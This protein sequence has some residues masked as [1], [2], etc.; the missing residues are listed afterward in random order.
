[1]H[2]KKPWHGEFIQGLWIIFTIKILTQKNNIGK[3]EL[4][5]I[6]QRRGSM[7]EKYGT[8]N[9]EGQNVN[10]DKLPIEEIKKY[11]I[12]VNEKEQK[13]ISQQ[14]EYLSQMIG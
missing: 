9:I 5:K 3:I 7:F 14:N 10:I 11:L 13:I 2:I 8:I 12:I 4:V 1:M 6:V